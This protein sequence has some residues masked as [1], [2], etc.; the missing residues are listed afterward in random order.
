MNPLIRFVWSTFKERTQPSVPFIGETSRTFRVLPTETDT[1]GQMRYGHYHQVIDRARG[2]WLR[3]SGVD[4][5]LSR[6]RWS[7]TVAGSVLQLDGPLKTWQRYCVTTR[8]VSWDE[9][10]FYFLHSFK[11]A[12]LR[13]VAFAGA[14]LCITDGDEVI[15][16]RH[17]TS[18]LAPGVMPGDPPD[19]VQAWLGTEFSL[20]ETSPLNRL[21]RQRTGLPRPLAVGH[22]E[23]SHAGALA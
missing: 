18:K 2:D 7:G 11:D 13:D 12:S 5:L 20:R 6:E 19:W 8:V 14:K 16:S 1:L 9:R 15:A 17:I 3:S 21:G 10:W 23:T 4:Q 22:P